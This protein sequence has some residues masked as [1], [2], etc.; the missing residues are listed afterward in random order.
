MKH[1]MC[2]DIVKKGP[3]VHNDVT[4]VTVLEQGIK[5]ILRGI[6]CTCENSKLR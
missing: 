3:C 2:F 6:F 5:F 4:R 1:T